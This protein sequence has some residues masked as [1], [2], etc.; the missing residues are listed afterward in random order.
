METN[1]T[2]IDNFPQI[3]DRQIKWFRQQLLKWSQQNFREFPWRQT[4]DPYA[5]FVAEFLLQKTDANKVL[6]V[7]KTFLTK[8]PTLQDLANANVEEIAT[9][10]KSLGLFF[11]AQRLLDSAQ[12]VLE[13]YKG[14]IPNSE[15]KLLELPGVGMY[16]ARSICTNSYQQTLAVLD[17]NIARIVERFFGIT[18]GRVKTRCKILWQAAEQIAP[19][20]EVEKWNLTLLDFGAKVCKAKNPLCIECPLQKQCNSINGFKL[21]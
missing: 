3:S 8:Y 17:S 19:D 18:G 7:Y 14:I 11:R 20:R 6:P 1:K 12:I 5:I 15:N 16:T 10:L 2:T 4:S 21:T 9:I 13:K